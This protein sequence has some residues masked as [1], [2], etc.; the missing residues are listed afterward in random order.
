MAHMNEL[1]SEP[2]V[3]GTPAEAR[4]AEYIASQFSSSGYVA[5]VVEFEFDG[6]RFRAGQVTVGSRT[7]E[8]LTLSGSPG[9]V[10]S[11]EGVYIGLA[12]EAGL[13]GKDVS[14]KIAVADRGTLNFIDKYQNARGAGA[15]GLVI[16]NNGPGPFSG[17]LA[18]QA[19]FPVV[20]VSQEDGA[21]VLE[22]AKSGGEVGIDAPPTVGLTKALNVVAKPT[23]QSRTMRAAQ[24]T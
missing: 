8:A 20:G 21:A 2:R 4:A 5:E 11:A 16:V 18:T 17:N 22:A 6:D 23:A 15:I 3:S 7:I 14:G 10:A 19:E 24:R 9:G 1:A 12:D 13:A